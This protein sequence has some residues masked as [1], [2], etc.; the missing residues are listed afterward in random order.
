MKYDIYIAP[1]IP[2]ITAP[3]FPPN[4]SWSPISSTLIQTEKSAVLVD[5]AITVEQNTSLAHWISSK[6]S[7]G[8]QLTHIYITHGHGDH[9]FG[10]P[11]LQKRFPGV[12]FIA[13]QGTL[14]HVKQQY[15]PANYDGIWNKFFPGQIA[16]EKPIPEAVAE[17]GE[18]EIDGH[19]FQALE[20]GH[21]DTFDT[22]VLHVPELKLVVGGDVVYG[23][24]NQHF[25]EAN[26]SEKRAE[27][28][29]ALDKVSSLGAEV[30]V[31]G[32]MKEEQVG[33]DSAEVLIGNTKK[34]IRDFEEEKSKAGTGMELF[35]SMK[36]NYPA[37]LNDFILMVA[38]NAAFAA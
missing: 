32:H 33:R 6:L 26:T 35:V 38:C 9:F 34:Y 5:T 31:A 20:V 7:P 23:D 18:F 3:P 15:E 1:V 17:N 19:L 25:G 14:E 36:K 29:N 8:V 37:R 16:E 22:T 10:V 2:M 27:W 21:T 4:L 28:L 11:L 30:V 24:C 12:K 13:T